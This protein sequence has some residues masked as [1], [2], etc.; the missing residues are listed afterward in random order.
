MHSSEIEEKADF[1]HIRYAQLWEDADVLTAALGDCTGRTLV[2]I[3]SAGDN[4]LAMLTL[5]PARVVVLDLSAAQIACLKLRIAAY[6]VLTHSEFIELTGSRPSKRRLALLNRVLE[7]TD[8]ETHA[9]WQ[10]LA[11]EV[12]RHGI[13]GVGKFERYFRIF[14]TWLL[15]LVH[16]RRTVDDVFTPRPPDAR[17]VFFDTRFNT[18]RWRLLLNTFFSRFVMGRMGRDSAFFD[19]VDGSPAQHVA[20]RLRHAGVATDPSQNPYLHWILKGT[21]GDALPM[22][23]RP[24]HYETVR[25]RLDR[26][27]IRLGSLEAFVATGEKASGFNLSDIFEYMSP[28]TFKQVY[29]AILSAAEPNARLVYWN[30]MAP[31]RVPAD[32]RDRIETLTEIETQQKA[33][34]LAFFYSDFVVE[35]VRP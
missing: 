8:A 19:H 29:G 1:D 27:D 34:D 33:R 31:R 18:F 12:N 4:A 32:Y 25:S 20:R 3:C 6:K 22:A 5:D 14:R 2:S 15:P 23:W 28:E 30:M 21:H 24:E 16:S 11:S 26:L 13:G 9:F 10:T 7:E 17:E 35:E